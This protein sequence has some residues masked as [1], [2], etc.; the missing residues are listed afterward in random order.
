MVMWGGGGGGGGGG[1]VDDDDDNVNVQ[2]KVECSG[3]CITQPNS[4]LVYFS[5]SQ[6]NRNVHIY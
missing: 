4:N 3:L 1:G 5:F 6:E 2:E